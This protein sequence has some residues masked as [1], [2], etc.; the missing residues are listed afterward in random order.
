MSTYSPNEEG[1]AD[2]CWYAEENEERRADII[3]DVASRLWQDQA[4]TRE[5]MLRAARMYGSLPMMGL[6]P[7]LYR[8]RTMSRGR[9][10][11]LNVVKS[12]VN[13]YVAM[14]TKDR[15]KVSFVTSG[16][17]DAIQR[18]AKRLEKFVDG[19][20]YDQSLHIQAY[21]CVRDSALFTFGIVKFFKDMSEPDKP[22]VGM[23]RTLPWEW[24]FDEQEAANGKPQNG[25]HVK[26]MDKRALATDVART[27]KDLAESVL[28]HANGGAFDDI[29]ETFD[30]VNTVEW[31]VV[32]EAWHLPPDSKTP[33]RHT[34]VCVG[35]D[36]PIVDEEWTYHRFPCEILYRERPI[37]GIHGESLADE[38][39]PIQVELSRM[40]MSI[41]R[42]QM[43]AVGHWVVEQNSDINTN[44]IDDVQAS[45][46]R[47]KGVPPRFEAH[48]TVANDVYGHLDR[49]WGRAFELVG[50]PQMNAAGQKP[51]GIDSGKGLLVYAEVTSTRFKPCYAEYQDWYM[52]VA[53]QIIHL[54]A[55]IAEDHKDFS[56]KAPGKM[57][58]AVK[59]ADVHM[60]EDE[61]VLQMYP[62][63]KLADDPA[64]RLSQVQAMINSGMIP[65][66]R[67]GRRLLDMPD[68]DSYSSSE[69]AS[70]D[71]VQEAMTRILEKGEMF[72]PEPYM[73][74]P[75][76]QEGL[77]IAQNTFL[78][79]R[80][81]SMPDKEA[82]LTMLT[83]W[84]DKCAGLI[85]EAVA[86]EQPPQPQPGPQGPQQ[87][88]ANDVHR[89]TAHSAAQQ[90]VGTPKT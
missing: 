34:I 45:I 44:Q 4:T 51:A 58:D 88:I 32:I 61:Y 6:S 86:A 3:V 42:A 36:K 68:M 54:A 77:K 15:P 2:V 78:S 33:G 39:G 37:Q 25:M 60:R 75:G 47:Y 43:Y 8:Q 30:Q 64:A 81:K 50:V 52:R 11:A 79:A 89:M 80:M 20:C 85:K 46:I 41:Q 12:V 74:L 62:T 1:N 83:V 56:V 57:M 72:P 67:A 13:T 38:L 53:Q 69:D 90:L 16:G 71:N 24:L 29:G 9:R 23:E 19:T 22:R 18:R 55:E 21:Q 31:C 49:L 17:D 28:Q 84:M 5:G 40:L 7:R 73:G 63:N 76:L 48:Q 82:K 65:D 87:A 59:W 26:F 35:V 27:D 70:Y 66:L 14:V 10:L